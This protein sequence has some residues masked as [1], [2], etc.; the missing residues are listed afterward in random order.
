MIN[1]AEIAHEA[2]SRNPL[3]IQVC[4][5][6]LRWRE[7]A[8]ASRQVVIP[9]QF[10]SVSMYTEWVNIVAWD[11]LVVIP[12]QF[13]SVSIHRKTGRNGG[14][15]RCRNPLS[16]Q[17]C[18]NPSWWRECGQPIAS[19]NPLSIQVCFNR[20]RQAA[21][22]R[23]RCGVVIPYQFRSVS[24]QYGKWVKTSRSMF[25]VIPYQFRSVSIRRNC[26]LYRVAQVE[27]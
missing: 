8:W 17:V 20:S 11:K 2:K 5:N 19:R 10:R 27:S 1:S 23:H 24:I 25:V 12:Y 16:I 21:Y 4:F 7:V 26:Q 3:S 13:R 9:Y 22:R 18:F 6:G 15:T 14:G